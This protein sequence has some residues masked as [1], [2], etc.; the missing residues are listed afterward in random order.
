[1]TTKTIRVLLVEDN[2]GDARLLEEALAEA[3]ASSAFHLT[4]VQTLAQTLA[5]LGEERFD[6][7]LLDLGLPDSQGLDAL[8]VVRA[9]APGTAI[10]VLTGLD[11]LMMLRPGG[12]CAPKIWVDGFPQQL[13]DRP[14]LEDIVRLEAVAAVE[15][16]RPRDEKPLHYVRANDTGCGVVLFWTKSGMGW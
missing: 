11:R 16:Y 9:L 13:G 2:P 10:V 1:M 7:L 15:V 4:H 5:L 3:P 12:V 6:L 8:T 14:S